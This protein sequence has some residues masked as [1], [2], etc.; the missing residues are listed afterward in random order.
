M[1]T[2]RWRYPEW[3]QKPFN[4]ADFR[5]AARFV[6]SLS[7]GQGAVQ[8]RIVGRR[9]QVRH[10]QGAPVA[11]DRTRHV[12][13]EQRD[14]DRGSKSSG[15]VLPSNNEWVKAA[16]YDPKGGGTDSYW[17]YP[18]GPFNPPHPSVLDPQT[19]DVVN[20]GTQPLSTYN[21]NDPNSSVDTPGSPP[22]PA[23]TWC[24]SAGRIQLR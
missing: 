2:I 15:F 3:A 24:P 5:R 7:N 17:A 1:S 4:F 13:H 18:T 9:V 14:G 12:R 6:N 20:A 22:G 23:P 21:P 8:D 19:G 16:Y 10:L 11:A